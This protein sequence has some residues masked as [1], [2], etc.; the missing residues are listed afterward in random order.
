MPQCSPLPGQDTSYKPYED[1]DI[2]N[3]RRSSSSE[4]DL[5]L[6][7]CQ[8][9]QIKQPLYRRHYRSILMHMLLVTFNI[10]FCLGVWQRPNQNCPYGVYGPELTYSKV[11]LFNLALDI[12][13]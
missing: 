9:L 7:K 8:A 3:T 12:H 1:Q 4:D 5:F 10:I 2:N 6:E 11:A 13:L